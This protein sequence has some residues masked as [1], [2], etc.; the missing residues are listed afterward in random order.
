LTHFTEGLS[1]VFSKAAA[2]LK[3]GGPFAF[4]YHHN[5]VEAYVPV[6]VAVL[7]AGLICT[8]TLPCPAEMT[9]SLH[10]NGTD[11]S[12]IDTIIVSRKLA[13]PARPV[14]AG[15][16]TLCRWLKDD[17]TRLAQGGITTTRGDLYCLALGHL[18]RVAV[19]ALRTKWDSAQPVTAKMEVVASALSA[20]VERCEMSVVV[21]NLSTAP[22]NVVVNGSGGKPERSLFDKMLWPR[23]RQESC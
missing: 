5:D 17:R 4:T 12:V 19:S 10:I 2:A 11:S 1:L 8:A 21:N 22:A 9:A 14:R 7:D 23:Q 18:A 15:K 16:A 13:E 3:P 20:L 6:V